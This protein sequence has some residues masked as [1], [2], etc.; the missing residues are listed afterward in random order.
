[1]VVLVV[2]FTL[3][4]NWYSVDIKRTEPPGRTVGVAVCTDVRRL[5]QAE[6]SR[7]ALCLLRT[8]AA[9]VGSAGDRYRDPTPQPRCR[10][11]RAAETA[12][13]IAVQLNRK[14]VGPSQ[15]IRED[16]ASS[17]GSTSPHR[18]GQS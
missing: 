10:T 14:C 16:L 3:V 17:S 12:A 13:A 15:C 8:H 2:G 4:M 18:P 6:S 9:R 1:M 7:R 11:S 5:R